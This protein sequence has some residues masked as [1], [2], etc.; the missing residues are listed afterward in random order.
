MLQATTRAAPNAPQQPGS[1]AG[2]PWFDEAVAGDAQPAEPGGDLPDE[3]TEPAA[4]EGSTEGEQGGS[5]GLRA[6]PQRE[7]QPVLPGRRSARLAEQPSG[8]FKVCSGCTG[9]EFFPWARGM[10]CQQQ[11]QQGVAHA[12]VA[13]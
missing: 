12:F 10:P 7:Q 11:Q 8:L 6:E 3:N 5:R 4:D 1:S 9:Q 2:W 13:P